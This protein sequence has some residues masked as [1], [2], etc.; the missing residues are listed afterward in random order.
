MQ[1]ID[2][3][4]SRPKTDSY[5]LP[6]FQLFTNL[7]LILGQSRFDE[8][9]VLLRL[10]VAA[11]AIKDSGHPIGSL[12]RSWIVNEDGSRLLAMIKIELIE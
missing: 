4:D 6:I 2:S 1:S 9:S 7:F 11:V 3:T 8:N 5:C 12:I 10:L